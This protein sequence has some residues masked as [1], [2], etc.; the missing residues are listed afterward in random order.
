MLDTLPQ[1]AQDAIREEWA[2][3]GRGNGNATAGVGAAAAATSS[4]SVDDH[5]GSSAQ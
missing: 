3:R 1:N 5:Y 4:D 2:A